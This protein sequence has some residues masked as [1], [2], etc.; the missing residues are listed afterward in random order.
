MNYKILDFGA[1]FLGLCCVLSVY[2]D[3]ASIPVF[4][5]GGFMLFIISL[6]VKYNPDIGKKE[7]EK[8]RGKTT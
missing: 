5:V 7:D 1:L 8:L 6:A 2:L 3:R 4:F